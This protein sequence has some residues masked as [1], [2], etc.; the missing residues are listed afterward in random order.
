MTAAIVTAAFAWIV[1]PFVTGPVGFD[2][3]ASVI[4]FD[5]I[6][7]GRRLEAFVTA[8]PKPL[9]TIVFG[10]LHALVPDWRVLSLATIAAGGL[11]VALLAQVVVRAMPARRR[12][13]ALLATPVLLAGSPLLLRDVALAY[14]VP[15]ALI[16]FALAALGAT[17]PRPRGWLLGLGLLLATLARLESVVVTGVL[18]LVLV[19]HLA[20]RRPWRSDTGWDARSLVLALVVA[21]LAL[22]VML[23][24]DWLLTGDPLFWA[25]VS[26]VY[27]A[28]ATSVPTVGDVARVVLREVTARPVASLLAG[29]GMVALA[30]RGSRALALGLLAM[31]PGL[32]LL[33][34]ALAARGT[35]VSGRY[36]AGIELAIL[37]AAAVGVGAIA[38]VAADRLAASGWRWAGPG[39]AAVTVALLAGAT[40]AAPFAPLD[41]ATR[42][43][44][45][46]Q[47]AFAQVAD[48]TVPVV[49]D[50]L[51]GSGLAGGQPAPAT[52]TVRVFAPFLLGPRLAVDLDLPLWTI[53]SVD[54]SVIDPAGDLLRPGTVVVHAR[55]MDR[56]LDGYVALE[57]GGEVMIG[58][59]R[60]DTV[61]RPAPE[62]WILL[63]P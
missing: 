11:A 17:G 8:T 12:W 33:L 46:S 22:P 29:V 59:H 7:G 48:S 30:W 58:E 37:V 2:S 57:A 45:D 60:L 25:K 21:S 49:A 39:R 1:F 44:V 20:T 9:L 35:Y 24:H 32:A 51:V 10:G 19:A 56:P 31:G 18:A 62:T 3:A 55:K 26:A 16:G 47:R 27:S 13:P 5:R 14:A 28:A 63:V 42:S 6:T 54:P 50:L 43:Y 61:A 36:Y 41:R 34:L 52:A 4:H 15:W 40:L 38:S 23:I 53:G